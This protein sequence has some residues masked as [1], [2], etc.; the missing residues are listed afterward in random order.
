[1]PAAPA[2]AGRAAE[3]SGVD[4]ESLPHATVRGDHLL[5]PLQKQVPIKKKPKQKKKKKTKKNAAAEFEPPS[6]GA[7]A[8]G[9]AFG[10]SWQ[11]IAKKLHR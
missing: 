2:A 5:S 10:S 7:D 3:G 9:R 4:G 6:V 1:M 11:Q 8:G